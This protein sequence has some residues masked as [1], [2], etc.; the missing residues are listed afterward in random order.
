MRLTSSRGLFF[1]AGCVYVSLTLLGIFFPQCAIGVED[2]L[3][4]AYH[5]ES[6]QFEYNYKSARSNTHSDANDFIERYDSLQRANRFSK[7]RRLQRESYLPHRYK[8]ED[9]FVGRRV[10]GTSSTQLIAAVWDILAKTNPDMNITRKSYASLITAV[11]GLRSHLGGWNAHEKRFQNDKILVHHHDAIN[12]FDHRLH[13]GKHS[14]QRAVNSLE[15]QLQHESADIEDEAVNELFDIVVLTGATATDVNFLEQWR[16]AIEFM[17]V[18]IIQQGDGSRTVEI[19]AWVN[20]VLYTRKDVKNAV[21]TEN[22]WI[23]DMEHDTLAALNFGF[24]ASDR[25]YIYVID[26]D[27]VPVVGGNEPAAGPLIPHDLFLSHALNLRKPSLPYYYSPLDPFKNGGF[28]TGHA[29][30]GR[31]YPFSL[32]GGV[33]TAVSIGAVL[34]DNPQDSLTKVLRPAETPMP[35]TAVTEGTSITTASTTA[36][37]DRSCRG[38]KIGGSCSGSSVGGSSGDDVETK[39]S[40]G[41]AAIQQ[42]RQQQRCRHYGAHGAPVEI[43]STIPHRQLFSL[44]MKNVA[45][46]RKAIGE[47]FIMLHAASSHPSF[48]SAE[49]GADFQLNSSYEVFSGWLLKVL[50]DNLHLGIKVT[51]SPAYIMTRPPSSPPAADHGKM[52][53]GRAEGHVAQETTVTSSRLGA[54]PDVV[55]TNA[56]RVQHEE[57]GQRRTR[58]RRRLAREDSAAFGKGGRR[59]RWDWGRGDDVRTDAIERWSNSDTNHNE[60]R[61]GSRDRRLQHGLHGQ[62][63]GSAPVYLDEDEL[64]GP[65]LVGDLQWATVQEKVLRYLTD[66][67]LS[68]HYADDV[69]AAVSELAEHMLHGL[70]PLH[71]VFGTAAHL[72]T[73]FTNLWN[74]KN[75]YNP[76]RLPIAKR[77]S[78]GPLPDAT[79]PCAMFTI[80]HNETFLLDLWLRHYGRHFPNAL[81]VL[82]HHSGSDEE[83]NKLRADPELLRRYGVRTVELYGD[84]AGFPM[85]FFTHSAE[86]MQQRLFK[87]GYK[88]SDIEGSWEGV[89]EVKEGGRWYKR[90]I[91]F[92][93]IVKP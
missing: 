18:I 64:F 25:D 85:G 21:G 69:G 76:T 84:K 36:E 55:L 7:R 59:G 68:T 87:M 70:G 58:Y 93:F 53:A 15:E 78:S 62:R 41:N 5:E 81:W 83:A 14:D 75:A 40:D 4:W 6:A 17:H 38:Q 27:T 12:I 39:G 61:T 10:R 88:V 71:P 56:I 16:G 45:F 90:I 2:E 22:A 44:S 24:I 74:Q 73:N 30:F 32:R 8:G 43:T 80:S 66:L 49:L 23:F 60:Y 29:D 13:R 82:N 48:S 28:D 63:A 37:K 57:A 79:H 67:Q 35:R 51:H 33:K 77:S 42:Q 9:P 52:V 50:C 31:G 34:Y 65:Q 20:Y 89:E 54:Q 47:A 19:P 11:D 92:F 72:M 1:I 26:R 86:L 46:D 91:A 3:L